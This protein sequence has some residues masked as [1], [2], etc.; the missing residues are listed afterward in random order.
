MKLHV[1]S[2]MPILVLFDVFECWKQFPEDLIATIQQS[3]AS[4]KGLFELNH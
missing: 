4:H 1:T 2:T 3:T